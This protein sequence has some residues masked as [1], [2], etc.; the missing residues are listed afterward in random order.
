MCALWRHD[1]DLVLHCQTSQLL[2]FQ[3]THPSLLHSIFLTCV[4]AKSTRSERQE[5]WDD[6]MVL[7][8]GAQS[9]PWAVG[10]DFN[11]IL[12]LDEYAGASTPDLSSISDFNGFLS[13]SDFQEISTTGGLFTWTGVRR[14]GRVW[15]KLD[16]LLFNS[17][18]L[19]HFPGGSVEV[20]SRATSDHAPLLYRVQFPQAS[21]PRSFKFQSMWT[22]RKDFLDVVKDSWEAPVDGFGMLRFSLKLRRLKQ[23]LRVWN[24]D[25]FG[26]VLLKAKEAEM[27]LKV[28][29]SRH[30]ASG[31]AADL[32]DLQQA[33]AHYLRTLSE[34]EAFW[35]QKARIRWLE[36]GDR[37]TK[38][39]HASVSSKRAKLPIHRIKDDAGNW[40]DSPDVI[41]QHAVYFFQNLLAPAPLPVDTAVVD[42]F[43]YHIPSILRSEDNAKLLAPVT[44]SEVRQAVFLLDAD[45]A[46]G[47]DGFSGIFYR[48]CWDII[49][50]DLHAAVLE[51]FHGVPLPRAVSHALIVLLPKSDSPNT[52]ADFRPIS[53]CNF[54]NKL[55][56]VFTRIL[57][58]RLK[59]FLPGLISE[60]QTA[61][62][63]GRDI[64]DNI[65]L[66]QEV[67]QH[68]DKRV[69]G[70][71]LL[72]KLDMMKAFDRVR[73]DFLQSLLL[74][75]GFHEHFVRL[76]FNNLSASCFSVLVN[77][78]PN[79]FFSNQPGVSSRAI[80]FLPSY[81]SLWLK[82]L[83]DL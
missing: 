69:R 32:V 16:R 47:P 27:D 43:L 39:Y 68:L 34:E 23:V 12:S 53:L 14:T 45:S 44:L 5:L 57:C 28:K 74:R 62:V 66:A 49:A 79:G 7:S 46:P 36:D 6:L 52:F 30:D 54:L 35:K 1:F 24:R 18:W 17:E 51:F 81:L 21:V 59:P 77:G 25:K 40:I 73:W 75:F 63:Q 78:V 42:Q 11:S 31:L 64:S 82:L 20:L 65:L 61:F 38:F 41:G 80:P 13:Q 71:N 8:T 3:V 56:K 29:E 2:H 50:S 60:E 55:N 70:H 10:G 26:N 37:N 22:G 72:F 4:Y 58:L 9:C 33:Q 15:K 48:T 76:I 67:L 19:Q 83:A